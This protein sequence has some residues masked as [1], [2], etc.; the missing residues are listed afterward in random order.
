VAVDANRAF[1]V[2]GVFYR[3][4]E[5]SILQ[6]VYL[7]MQPSQICGLFGLNGSGKSTV[8]RVAAGQ[9]QP[10]SGLTI[11]DGTRFHKPSR[12]RRFQHIAYLPQD[13]MLPGDL[14]VR[15]LL[16]TLP[17]RG[18]AL[19]TDSIVEPLLDQRVEEL[20]GGE[21]RYLATRFVL[22]LGRPYV[23]LD[24]PSPASSRASSTGSCNTSQRLRQQ[25]PAC[26][27]PII[28]ISTCC[29]SSTRRI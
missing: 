22:R 15:S 13:S 6:G 1:V 21:R 28:I 20:S 29:R 7:K 12:R 24:S 10:S 11:I 5:Q 2:D 8:L 26:S 17:D 27:S 9:L 16:K 19:H 18:R 3:V 14:R 4:P 23:L 25:A